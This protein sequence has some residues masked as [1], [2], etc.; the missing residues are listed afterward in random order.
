MPREA[1]AHG[2]IRGDKKTGFRGTITIDG[3]RRFARGAKK[4]V[5]QA[6]LDAYLEAAATEKARLELDE[7][8]AQ[9][10]GAAFE[11]WIASGAHTVTTVQGHK[12]LVNGLLSKSD[13]WPKPIAETT[14]AEI[15][16]WVNT[17]TNKRGE[18]A[19]MNTK[20]MVLSISKKTAAFALRTGAF[21]IS[22]N[23]TLAVEVVRRG[24]PAHIES[25]S[26]AESDAVISAAAR[27][28][29]R[30]AARWS[31]A[32]HYGLRPA[33]AL[34]L[35]LSDIDVE[36]EWIRVTVQGTLVRVAGNKFTETLWVHQKGTKTRAGTRVIPVP[37]DSTAGAHLLTHLDKLASARAAAPLRADQVAYLQAQRSGLRQTIA[38]GLA[39]T[40]IEDRPLTLPTDW[41]FP[42][43]D[44]LYMPHPHD[45]DRAL[46][47]RT[48][49]DAGFAVAPSRY[50]ARHTAAT[51]MLN[52]GV[53]DIAV[54][55]IMGHTDVNF[56][57]TR[58]ADS[59]EDRTKRLT[60]NL[61]RN[62]AEQ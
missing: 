44:H 47:Q 53:D 43:P 60:A 18:I 8:K 5:V 10:W 15:N 32:L 23:P 49:K 14:T 42:H 25:M 34:A 38:E 50:V 21:G 40:V 33:E 62:P 11:G 16:E 46:W 61:Y 12:K 6:K 35:R 9:T 51:H 29:A 3:Q 4:S 19:S 45:S 30:S 55:E 37:R 59:L 41:V 56:T 54:S 26:R 7:F 22:T 17:L 52:S 1:A 2:S 24:L 31:L 57:R 39:G 27:D 20:N 36:P 58:Y 48:C 28:S 13:W